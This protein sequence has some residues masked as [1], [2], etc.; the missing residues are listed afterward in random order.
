MTQRQTLICTGFESGGTTVGS[1]KAFR[2]ASGTWS[3]QAATDLGG[4]RFLRLQPGASAAWVQLA[5]D[6]PVA[7]PGIGALRFRFVSLPST[8]LVI[9]LETGGIAV[10]TGWGFAYDAGSG[11]IRPFVYDSG[12]GSFSYGS[13]SAAIQAGTVYRIEFQV[14]GSMGATG[15]T[16]TISW[17][18][19]E[20]D[21]AGT[22]QADFAYTWP[23]TT[24]VGNGLFLGNRAGPSSACT[25]DIDDVLY[26]FGSGDWPSHP[27]GPLRVL[28]LRPNADGTHSNPAD[29]TGSEG[30]SPPASE[31]W[32]YLDE[33]PWGDSTA[34]D[35]VY[36]DAANAGSYLEV[37]L[38]DPPPQASGVL[39]G[40][41]R[42]TYSSPT[43]GTANATVAAHMADGTG[44]T[45][46]IS[47]SPQTVVAWGAV[48]LIRTA[49]LTL[50]AI[51]GTVLR[52]GKSTDV[53]PIIR[54]HTAGLEVAF[55]WGAQ[56]SGW[57]IILA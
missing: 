6:G 2:G 33:V 20:G 36:Q 27:I 47:L 19:A 43:T 17:R 18:L 12:S 51:A 32:T 55:G 41:I 25:L 9:V 3:I 26:M 48:Q 44:Y 56:R 7:W 34:N 23:A 13:P 50:D 30:S 14:V 46:A 28:L 31:A 5:Q 53:D 15:N 10:P 57:G 37:G 11:G 1:N 40:A 52:L 35:H 21:G 38:T 8:D 39:G 16:G 45:Q 22:P 29:F 54:I 24:G 49:D 42:C 4:E